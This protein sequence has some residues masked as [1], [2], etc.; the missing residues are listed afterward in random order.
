[1]KENFTK[2]PL[3]TER[4]NFLRRKVN[5]TLGDL[6]REEQREL[7]GA[8]D[9]LRA[10][11]N[12]QGD[13]IQRIAYAAG[14]TAGDGIVLDR[15]LVPAIRNLY[16]FKPPWAYA[17]R[18]AKFLVADATGAWIW[19]ARMPWLTETGWYAISGRSIL[20]SLGAVRPFAE[21]RDS[22]EQRP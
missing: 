1:M 13:L 4:L 16:R 12:E 21:W 14:F 19:F 9:R 18:W 6:S 22:L 3:T 5:A 15:D 2:R 20:A 17:P 11:V 10:Q 7:M 8:H